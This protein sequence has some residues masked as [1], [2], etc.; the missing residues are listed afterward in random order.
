MALP[1]DGQLGEAWDS[2]SSPI[3]LVGFL[4]GLVGTLVYAQGTTRRGPEY[5]IGDSPVLPPPQH[6]TKWTYGLLSSPAARA[7]VSQHVVTGCLV[8]Q[9]ESATCGGREHCRI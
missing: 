4:L 8:P 3:Q 5:M 6:A 9:L 1:A 7:W 2:R